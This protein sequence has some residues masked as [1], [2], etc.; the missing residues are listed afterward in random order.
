MSLRINLPCMIFN[1]NTRGKWKPRCSDGNLQILEDEIK[2]TNLR[3]LDANPNHDGFSPHPISTAME[4][5]LC[6]LIL[7]PPSQ[8]QFSE[9]SISKANNSFGKC[10][11][12][13]IILSFSFHDFSLLFFQKNLWKIEKKGS[14]R[15]WRRKRKKKFN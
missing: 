8:K 6:P 15:D 1:C 7:S 14:R 9:S 5:L 10:F 4:Q 12:K 11:G 2:S 3:F 13:F